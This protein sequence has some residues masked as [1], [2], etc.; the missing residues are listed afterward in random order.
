[1]PLTELKIKVN[2]A[3]YICVTIT[4]RDWLIL[5]GVDKLIFFISHVLKAIALT[6]D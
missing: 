3:I 6:A 1:M 4:K 2:I 5:E